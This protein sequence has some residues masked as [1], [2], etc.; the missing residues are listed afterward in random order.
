M[1]PII[2]RNILKLVI[3]KIILNL[4]LSLKIVI[5]VNILHLITSPINLRWSK[6]YQRTSLVTF[7]TERASSQGCFRSDLRR[8]SHVLYSDHLH[9][10]NVWW[11]LR[12][13]HVE[14]T[15]SQKKSLLLQSQENRIDHLHSETGILSPNPQFSSLFRILLVATHERWWL[16]VSHRGALP[17]F[18]WYLNRSNLTRYW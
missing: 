14:M 7:R 17:Y 11:G 1:T 3:R 15:Q 10:V 2:I 5:I 8:R 4:I 9:S 16:L 18:Y 13:P 6:H 12:T